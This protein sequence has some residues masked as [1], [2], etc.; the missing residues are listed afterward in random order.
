MANTYSTYRLG[1]VASLIFGDWKYAS[2]LFGSCLLWPNG[3]WMDQD[4]TWHG[5]SPRPWGHCVRW[6]P[7]SPSTQRGTAVPHFSAHCCRPH[8]RRPAYYP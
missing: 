4:T 3:W 1:A 7:S 5:V 6:G 2:P 8:P